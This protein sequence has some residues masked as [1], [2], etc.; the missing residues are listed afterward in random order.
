MRSTVSFVALALA[1]LLV[2]AVAPTSMTADR[3]RAEPEA[4]GVSWERPVVVY[5][6]SG[7]QASERSSAPTGPK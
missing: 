3:L 1:V 2:P 4:A 7:H 5:G 6:D